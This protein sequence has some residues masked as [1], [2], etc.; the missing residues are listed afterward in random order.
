[1]KKPFYKLKRFYIP[2]SVLVVLIIFTSLVYH[3]LHRPLEL[4]FGMGIIKKKN[5]RV[6]RIY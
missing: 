2:C 3:F 4:I 5:I 6:Q 1:M